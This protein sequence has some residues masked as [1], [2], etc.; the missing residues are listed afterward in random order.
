MD[1]R[2]AAGWMQVEPMLENGRLERPR[3]LHLHIR[4]QWPWGMA[5]E[6]WRARLR[7]LEGPE[8]DMLLGTSLS[9]RFVGLPMWMNHPANV[10]GFYG[11][12]V[13][14]ALVLPYR[15]GYPDGVWMP[16]WMYH[17]SLLLAS[18]M[19]LGFASVVIVR[20]TGRHPVAPLRSVLYV[21]PFVGLALLGFNV[22]D[23]VEVPPAI[24]WFLLLLPGPLYVHLS[25]APRWR[26]LCMLEDGR[27]PFAGVDFEGPSSEAT[28]ERVVDDDSDLKDVLDALEAPGADEEA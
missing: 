9:R 28:V 21:M 24:V 10:A 7:E 1:Q 4:I 8:A 16:T 6:G 2:W 17:T 12:L 26:L 27:D 23:M 5:T 25:W 19:G 18:C 20:L 3:P 11:L 13:S 22:S 14:L 15:F